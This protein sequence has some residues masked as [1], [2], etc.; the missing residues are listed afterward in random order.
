MVVGQRWRSARVLGELGDDPHRFTDAAAVRCFAGTA[1][2]T[3]ASGRS[4]VVSARRICSRRLDDARHWWAYAAISRFS[5]GLAT[6]ART[7]S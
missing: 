5:A 2:I 6:A 1:P 3:R 4:R 7:A